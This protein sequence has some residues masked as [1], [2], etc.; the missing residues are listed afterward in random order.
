MLRRPAPRDGAPPPRDE[1]DKGDAARIPRPRRRLRVAAL[2][3]AARGVRDLRKDALDGPAPQNDGLPRRARARRRGDGAPRRAPRRLSNRR[4]GLVARLAHRARRDDPA[5][6]LG[7]AALRRVRGAVARPR[8]PAPPPDARGKSVSDGVRRFKGTALR[9]RRR[10]LDLPRAARRAAVGLGRRPGTAAKD[11]PRP[12]RRRTHRRR[13]AGPSRQGGGRLLLRQEALPPRG[14]GAGRA[15]RG[16]SETTRRLFRA[17]RGRARALA[18]V[19]RRVVAARLRRQDRR[20]RDARG[21]RRSKRRLRQREIQ[22]SPLPLRV[23]RPRRGR[24]AP[25]RFVGRRRG[26]EDGGARLGLRESDRSRAE[27]PRAARLRALRRAAELVP[28]RREA[29]GLV[30]RPLVG[31]GA[32]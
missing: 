19:R 28:A 18:C 23:P 15:R 14:A 17:T 7:D 5:F 26:R 25:V 29:Q 9:R 24:R 20:D 10:P 22:R 27:P 11:S 12:R 31:V 3:V 21:L 4:R 13:G 1:R 6:P 8:A 30:R 2:R 32:F 16:R